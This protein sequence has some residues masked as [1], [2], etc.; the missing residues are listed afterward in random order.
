MIQIVLLAEFISLIGAIIL[1][2]ILYTRLKENFKHIHR[3]AVIPIPTPKSF[4]I[5]PFE[6][7]FT[8]RKSRFIIDKILSVIYSFFLVA[9]LIA[10][11]VGVYVAFNF[12]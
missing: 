9:I 2:S 8:A 11:S 1:H 4:E 3:E 6:L 12:P 10:F 7:F 5:S